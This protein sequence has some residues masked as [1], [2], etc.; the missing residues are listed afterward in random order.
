MFFWG[1]L[2]GSKTI[3]KNQ[4]YASSA[5]VGVKNHTQQ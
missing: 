4:K 3:L 1:I 5:L 2:V